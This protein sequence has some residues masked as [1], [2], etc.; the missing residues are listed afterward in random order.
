MTTVIEY[1]LTPLARVSA[2][3]G[4][5]LTNNKAVHRVV[6]GMT[7]RGA[8]G[9]TRLRDPVFGFPDL[10]EDAF[11]HR[12]FENIGVKQAVPVH[13]HAKSWLNPM[14][15]VTC[16]YPDQDP[17]SATRCSSDP[18]WWDEA[19]HGLRERCDCRSGLERGR[20]GRS[21]LR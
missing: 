10:S 15:R 19:V 7:V 12:F 2:A 13:D 4:G 20:D 21:R 8:L 5:E 1:L 14:S 11:E 18:G 17:E 3:Q 9:R 6:P 16:K